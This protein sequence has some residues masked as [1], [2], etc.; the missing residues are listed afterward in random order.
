[1]G[2]GLGVGWLNCCFINAWS[3]V[4][5]ATHRLDAVAQRPLLVALV[6]CRGWMREMDREASINQSST[7]RQTD[8]RTH[9][10]TD[11]NAMPPCRMACATALRLSTRTTSSDPSIL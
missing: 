10:R 5:T 2:L 11:K 9:A 7:D 4:R 8:R 3:G 1:M 6:D